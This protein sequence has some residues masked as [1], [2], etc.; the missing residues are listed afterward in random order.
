[1]AAFMN[2]FLKIEI[3]FLLRLYAKQRIV[4]R[5]KRYRFSRD[6]AEADFEFP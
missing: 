5:T 2:T 1:M 3:S 4:H 6:P